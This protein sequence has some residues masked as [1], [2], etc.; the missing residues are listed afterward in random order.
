L[1]MMRGL[2]MR[3]WLL[4]LFANTFA[5]M[6]LALTRVALA[7]LRAAF[8]RAGVVRGGCRE[9]RQASSV[10]V[11]RRRWLPHEWGSDGLNLSTA[12]RAIGAPS[13]PRRVGDTASAQRLA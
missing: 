1:L 11:L 3:G 5:L 12:R 6:R 10:F 2:S 8:G 7:R 13:A 4:S 9:T